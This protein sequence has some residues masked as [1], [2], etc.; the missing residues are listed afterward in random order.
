MRSTTTREKGVFYTGRNEKKAH[1]E[2]GWNATKK[3]GT[4]ATWTPTPGGPWGLA[5]FIR[6]RRRKKQSETLLPMNNMRARRRES[7]FCMGCWRALHAI[8][9]G[10]G[11]KKSL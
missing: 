5:T 2:K 4:R 3:E 9:C 10:P 8:W 7:S 1:E 11:G 6:Q